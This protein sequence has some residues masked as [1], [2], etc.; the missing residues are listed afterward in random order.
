MG[1]VYQEYL[2]YPL[3]G[4]GTMALVQKI[5]PSKFAVR[6]THP[7]PLPYSHS[8]G[9]RGEERRLGGEE[10]GGNTAQ[11]SYLHPGL[12]KAGPDLSGD[13]TWHLYDP[14]NRSNC[15]LENGWSCAKNRTTSTAVSCPY[16]SFAWLNIVCAHQ[17][18]FTARSVKVSEGAT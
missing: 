14:R 2:P 1:K 16:L 4:W 7:P 8:P 11:K 10:V 18:V 13:F 6:A 5:P 15:F 17:W 12:R 3:K 9:G